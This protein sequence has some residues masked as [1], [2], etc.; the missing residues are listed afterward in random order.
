MMPRLSVEKIVVPIR[1]EIPLK[2]SVRPDDRITEALEVMLKNDLKQIAVARGDEVLGMIRLE[3]ALNTVGLA[4]G[5]KPKGAPSLVIHG[6]K[7]VLE[8]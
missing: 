7:I 4:R 1:G 8:E 2:P 3:D 6:R 5:I